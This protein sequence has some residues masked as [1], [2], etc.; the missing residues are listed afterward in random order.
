MGPLGWIAIGCGAI[1]LLGI[2]ALAVGGYM[3]KKKVIDPAKENPTM[4]AAET[5]VRLNPEL[6]LVSSDRDKNTLTVKNTKT[7]EVVTINAEDIKDGKIT[8]ETAEGKTVVDASQSGESGNIKVTGADGQ[9]LT[10][11]GEA[12][13]NLPEWVPVYPGSTVAG[14]MDATNAEGRTAS[15]SITTEDGIDDVIPY[16]E[17]ALREAGL[18][19]SKTT[20]ESNGEPSAILTGSSEDD[21]KTISVMIGSQDGKTTATVNFS[22]KN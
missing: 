8:F 6:E 9:Q 1:V 11:G 22:A 13:K 12:P 5:L 4:A 16:Y 15:F 18:K 10:I 20:M 17:S 14:A 3:F 21:K 19:V 2:L 7:G